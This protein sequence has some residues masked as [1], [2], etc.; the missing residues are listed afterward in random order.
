MDC[1]HVVVTGGEPMIWDDLVDLCSELRKSGKHITIETAG[2]VYLDLECD[3]MS[4]SPK[5]SNSTPTP[6]LAG[7]W[8]RRHEETRFR[9][10]IVRKCL[11][12][13]EY[14]LKFVVDRESDAEEVLRFLDA[15]GSVDRDRVLLMPQGTLV[16]DLDQ[17]AKWL[18]PWCQRHE[19]RYCDRAHIRWFGQT[20][21]T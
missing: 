10:D 20:R 2:T 19:V 17:R 21:G 1:R 14:Q 18:I 13:G 15:V 3:L 12:L 6:E 5:M 9:P 16:E 11:E 8:Q 7:S 4:I